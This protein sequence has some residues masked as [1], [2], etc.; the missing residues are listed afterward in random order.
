L[1]AAWGSILVWS[2]A[3]LCAYLL[4][5]WARHLAKG[6]ALANPTLIAILL[7]GGALI[8]THTPYATYLKASAPITILLAP[9]TVA[10]GL[11][12]AENLRHVRQSL[13]PLILALAAGSLVA[14]LSGVAVI[15]AFGAGRTLALTL[16]PKAATSP[17]SMAVAR[18]IGVDPSLT[19][20]MT[21]LGGIIAAV[22][23][24]DGLKLM[25]VRDW[26]AVGLA[27]GTAGGGIGAARVAPLNSLAAAFAGIG[28]GLN[29]LLTAVL[30][31]LLAQA[32]R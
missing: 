12:L 7:I 22:L 2:G 4:G 8:L 21:I 27:A 23:V 31:P 16:A 14:M 11:P 1:T 24:R 13:W 6:A 9:A 25:G 29:G 3:T 18:Q 28:I 15:Y 30:V 32:L 5:L 20:V 17:I 19:A 26:R 10:L